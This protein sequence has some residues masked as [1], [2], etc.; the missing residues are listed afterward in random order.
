[1][2]DQLEDPKHNYAMRYIRHMI[3]AGLPNELGQ[4]V[5]TMLTV[6][7]INNHGADRARPILF[8]NLQLMFAAGIKSMAT[9]V[10]I[11]QAAI[12]AGWLQYQAGKKSAPGK[13][14]VTV[15][16]QYRDRLDHDTNGSL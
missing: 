12:D 11:R 16:E 8:F 1:M 2:S 5:F 10:A 9:L 4:G 13:Y 15:P 6:I 14:L 3:D 7:S